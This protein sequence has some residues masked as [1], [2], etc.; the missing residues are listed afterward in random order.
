M[1]TSPME[2]MKKSKVAKGTPDEEVRELTRQEESPSS[3]DIVYG[4]PRGKT[5]YFS[6]LKR[7]YKLK[8][9]SPLPPLKALSPVFKLQGELFEAKMR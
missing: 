7:R 6:L 1:A 8:P 4:T 3:A 5:M 2:T 9:V